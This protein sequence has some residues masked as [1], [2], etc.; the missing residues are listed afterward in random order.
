MIRG[1]LKG[2]YGNISEVGATEI[3]VE[4]SAFVTGASSP[5]QNLKWPDIMP[6][7]LSIYLHCSGEMSYSFIL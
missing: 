5:F 4:L 1:P 7:F 6:M 3:T 2:L